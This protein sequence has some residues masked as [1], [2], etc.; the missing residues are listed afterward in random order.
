[1][2]TFFKRTTETFSSY[3]QIRSIANGE[4]QGD[5]DISNTIRGMTLIQLLILMTIVIVIFA[6]SFPPWR[7]YRRVS[8]ADIDVETIAI[9]VKKYFKHTQRYPTTFD[10]LITDS[11][12][13][14][15]RGNYL[16]S[17]PE[18]PWGGTYVLHVDAYKVGISKSHPRVPTK[19]RLGGISEISRVY[20]V[21]VRLGEKYFFAD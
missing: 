13:K 12:V 3:R 18:T 7:E 14:G 2:S 9:A 15:W 21:D 10:E 19:Y 11:G 4:C 1:M 6:L 20:H 8:E 5:A 16:E 17:T